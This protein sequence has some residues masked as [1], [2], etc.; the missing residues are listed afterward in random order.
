VKEHRELGEVIIACSSIEGALLTRALGE[1]RARLSERA[2]RILALLYGEKQ[3]M[4]AQHGVSSAVR[5][6]RAQAIEFLD[7]VLERR[8]ATPVLR[9]IEG[10]R[11]EKLTLEQ[12]L[13]RVAHGEDA[14]L[15]ACVVWCA[16][17]HFSSAIL[18]EDPEIIV[19][20]AAEVRCS[21]SSRE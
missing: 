20:E 8:I 12:A 16:A 17:P 18:L 4:N 9:M 5:T 7:N 2:F 1:K 10:E 6:V 14:W 15:R 19:R 21:P 13:E 11:G 3:M